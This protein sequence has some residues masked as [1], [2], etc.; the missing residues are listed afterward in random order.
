MVAENTNAPAASGVIE[1]AVKASE[2]RKTSTATPVDKTP[3]SKAIRN[4]LPEVSARKASEVLS[5][6]AQVAEDALSVED[7]MALVEKLK[8]SLPDNSR[9]LRF[10]V[11]E[12][13]NRPIMSVFDSE[14][15][16]L[17]RQLPSE[18]VVRAARNIELMRGILF[19]RKG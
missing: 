6:A 2:V 12:V 18:E 16:K 15:G 9:S 4:E 17:I 1:G 13:L 8:A 7:L 5:D 14:S 11:D 19:D 10:S 3:T